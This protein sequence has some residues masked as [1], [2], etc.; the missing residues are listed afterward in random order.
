VGQQ[1]VN[2][3]APEHARTRELIRLDCAHR[4]GFPKCHK[5]P[6]STFNPK[7]AGSIPARPIK[8]ENTREP[9]QSTRDDAK[10]AE[11]TTNTKVTG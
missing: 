11:C 3:A 10:A 6:A 2:K 4:P 1:E 9:G 7:V 8:S 5:R